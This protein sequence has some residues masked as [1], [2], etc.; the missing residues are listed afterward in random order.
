MIPL[1]PNPTWLS[2]ECV[3]KFKI[4]HGDE[5]FAYLGTN[6]SVNS[7]ILEAHNFPINNM[8]ID[9]ILHTRPITNTCITSRILQ[10]K[11]L[12]ASKYVYV[13]TLL[14]SPSEQWFKQ[15]DQL[16]TNHVW[17]NGRH[18]IAKNKM[19]APK[20]VGGFKMLDKRLQEKSLKLRWIQRL[21]DH[22]N[23]SMWCEYVI[24]AFII[25]IVD[26]LRVNQNKTGFTILLCKPLPQV[27]MDI[28]A[29]WYESNYIP[30]T[31]NS[32]EK[33]NDLL[34]SLVCFCHPV[35][36]I[37]TVCGN[38][39]IVYQFL[40]QNNI[41]ISIKK[42]IPPQWQFIFGDMNEEPHLVKSHRTDLCMIGITTVKVQLPM[43][44]K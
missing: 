11:T 9:T 19:I 10:T 35:H 40:E 22:T 23:I 38:K 30:I 29:I 7:A 18:R 26:P 8:L 24:S 28:F 20:K 31:C 1:T 15:M 6:L 3:S 5:Y 25:P 39:L 34:N 4:M 27:W 32:K 33:R 17:D 37:P 41:L 43:V 12:I 36:T 14:P 16:L 44:I 13:F 2:F 21:L 42:S